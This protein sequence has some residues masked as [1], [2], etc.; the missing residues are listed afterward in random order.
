MAII[1]VITRTRRIFIYLINT[2]RG[3]VA[4]TGLNEKGILGILKCQVFNDLHV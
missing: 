4:L 3:A 1:P 2:D